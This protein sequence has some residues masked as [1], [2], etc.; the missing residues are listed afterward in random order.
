MFGANSWGCTSSLSSF[1]PTW[2][3][4]SGLSNGL[5]G[6]SLTPHLTSRLILRDPC[7]SSLPV[8]LSSWPWRM[9][10]TYTYHFTG[11]RWEH[12]MQSPWLYIQP[13]I[14]PWILAR[15]S[16]WKCRHLKHSTSE[17]EHVF[18]IVSNLPPYLPTNCFKKKKRQKKR[19][20]Y[21][22]PGPPKVSRK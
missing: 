16:S 14:S 13:A 18:P 20:S 11:R 3:G 15:I 21:F 2:E 7:E 5:E 1:L 12:G 9:E 22:S 19:Y 17:I 6:F 4:T 8:L 10:C